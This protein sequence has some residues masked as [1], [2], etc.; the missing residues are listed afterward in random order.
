MSEHTPAP[1]PVPPNPT[2][3]TGPANGGE[4]TSWTAYIRPTIWTLIALYVIFFVFL[5]RDIVSINFIFFQ[6]NIALIFVL[7]GMAIIGGGITATVLAVVRRR[8]K[9]AAEMEALRQ[10]AAAGGKK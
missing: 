3:V 2:P 10:Q 5:N 9:R 7:V 8:K 1:Q 6:A 4:S